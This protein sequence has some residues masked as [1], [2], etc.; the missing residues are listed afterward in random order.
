[1]K[2]QQLVV[3]VSGTTDASDP[4]TAALF[5]FV[6]P[7]GVTSGCQSNKDG[8]PDA[9]VDVLSS[10]QDFDVPGPFSVSGRSDIALTTPGKWWFCA[11]LE[12]LIGPFDQP[13]IATSFVPFSVVPPPPPPCIRD[14]GVM[15]NVVAHAVS[16]CFMQAG[17]LDTATGDVLVNG[18]DLHAPGAPLTVN[19]NGRS[20]TGPALML[21]EFPLSGNLKNALPLKPLVGGKFDI[22]DAAANGIQIV[23]LPSNAQIFSVPLVLG[24]YGQFGDSASTDLS[25]VASLKLLGAGLEGAFDLTTDNQYLGQLTNLHIAVNGGGN[26]S[27]APSGGPPLGGGQPGKHYR[28]HSIYNCRKNPPRGFKCVKDKRVRFSGGGFLKRSDGEEPDL[29]HGFPI[30]NLT[31]DYTAPFGLP[32]LGEW[33]GHGTLSLASVLPGALQLVGVSP[34]LSLGASFYV[35]P[36]QFSGADGDLSGVNVPLFGAVFLQHIGASV[37]LAHRGAQDLKIS[38]DIGVSA[39]PKL[40]FLKKPVASIDGGFSWQHGNKNGFDLLIAGELRLETGN[41]HLAGGS[42]EYDNRDRNGGGA[43]VTAKGQLG[44][45]YGKDWLNVQPQF[46]V[47]GHFTSKHFELSG[48]GQAKVQLGPIG[49]GPTVT[50]IISDKGFGFCGHLDALFFHGEVGISKNWAGDWQWFTCDFSS[51]ETIYKVQTSAA[52]GDRAVRVRRGLKAVQIAVSAPGAPPHVTLAGPGGEQIAAPSQPDQPAI[53]ANAL[54]LSESSTHTTYF[55][56]D[57]PR[58]GRWHVIPAATQPGPLVVKAAYP[59]PRFHLHARISGHGHRRTL[60]WKAPSLPGIS[61]MFEE[62]GRHVF[63][64]IGGPRS[65]SGRLSFRPSKGPAGRRTI[66]VRVEH[67]GLPVRTLIAGHY[68]ARGTPPPRGPRRAHRRLRGRTLTV[69]WSRVRHAIGYVV[70]V[71]E[72]DRPATTTTWSASS[73]H[74]KLKLHGRKVRRAAV[75]ALVNGLRS[76]ATIARR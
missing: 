63:A 68:R 66:R 12:D 30:R 46:N 52:A 61:Y 23:D 76:R 33:Q 29:V 34:E 13:P 64:R 14:V 26:K 19:V 1:V 59:L 74:A 53:T 60:T 69:S 7:P 36:L 73:R 67:D 41:L 31:L 22:A 45:K 32:F 49:G 75:V 2:G 39:G 16:G 65:G 43:D 17:G 21:L 5:A 40:P 71:H 50:A 25:G 18:L 58:V 15:Q 4:E 55:E 9:A 44:G 62:V 27:E 42:F 54:T 72:R 6:I 11:Y 57:H 3:T 37:H 24:V 56:I 8:E 20:L 35:N 28:V 48:K 10:N 47:E 51:L 38:G 70:K